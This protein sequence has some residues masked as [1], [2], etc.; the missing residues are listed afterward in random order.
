M[1]LTQKITQTH[2]KTWPKCVFFPWRTTHVSDQL[3]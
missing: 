3:A 1:L 2:K